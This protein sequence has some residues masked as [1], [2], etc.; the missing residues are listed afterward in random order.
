MKR[1]E[2]LREENCK[3]KKLVADLALDKEMLKDVVRGNI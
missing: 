2:Q 3:L 1:L